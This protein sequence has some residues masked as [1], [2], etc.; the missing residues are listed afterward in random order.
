MATDIVLFAIKGS[1]II[2]ANDAGTPPGDEFAEWRD[3][4]Y[5]QR[6]VL[7]RVEDGF[8]E[9]AG[10]AHGPFRTEAK[11]RIDLKLEYWRRAEEQL[12]R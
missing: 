1:W 4:H 12:E 6:R 11:A 3:G 9:P 5:W 10:A 8:G 2:T 7:G